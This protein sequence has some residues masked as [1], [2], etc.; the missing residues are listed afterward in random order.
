MYKSLFLNVTIKLTAIFLLLLLHQSFQTE[1]EVNETTLHSSKVANSIEIKRPQTFT[2]SFY[3]VPAVTRNTNTSSTNL[4]I[5]PKVTDKIQNS[6]PQISI[7]HIDNVILFH[8]ISRVVLNPISLKYLAAN[9]A[10]YQTFFDTVFAFKQSISDIDMHFSFCKNLSSY[11]M[12][13]ADLF[14]FLSI[15]SLPLETAANAL[16]LQLLQTAISRCWLTVKSNQRMRDEIV[17]FLDSINEFTKL[18]LR[19]QSRASVDTKPIS[20]PVIRL[21]FREMDRSSNTFSTLFKRLWKSILGDRNPLTRRN[22]SSFLQLEFFDEMHKFTKTFMCTNAEYSKFLRVFE[23]VAVLKTGR[24]TYTHRILRNGNLHIFKEIVHAINRMGVLLLTENA[25]NILLELIETFKIFFINQC[26]LYF[27]DL[28][29]ELT[30]FAYSSRYV[31]NILQESRKIIDSFALV[32]HINL[33]IDNI[34]YRRAKQE[35]VPANCTEITA[36]LTVTLNNAVFLNDFPD[37]HINSSVDMNSQFQVSHILQLKNIY[38]RN[39]LNFNAERFRDDVLMNSP[40]LTNI[41]NFHSTIYNPNEFPHTAINR[42]RHMDMIEFNLSK[43]NPSPFDLV[44]ILKKDD[45]F[46]FEYF[47]YFLNDFESSSAED[48][49]IFIKR[50]LDY[51]TIQYS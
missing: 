22:I 50:F 23:I 31:K 14:F 13:S 47:E 4:K 48:K 33:A 20:I 24:L 9:L 36:C 40:L 37:S 35:T 28:Y 27:Y 34:K 42:R 38:E 3:H 15:L 6:M 10:S 29:N 17:L 8:Q 51:F 49:E 41:H 32:D 12:A 19:I 11:E 1:M 18:S 30:Q 21:V 2:I 45:N 16:K 25:F 7:Y 46:N 44:T 43:P 26:A 39:T 5:L